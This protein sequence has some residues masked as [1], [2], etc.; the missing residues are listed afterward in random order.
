MAQTN[1]SRRTFLKQTA[2]PG[3]R[4]LPDVV[5]STV[6]GQGAPSNKIVMGAI[7]TG[8]MGMGDLNGFL[9]KDEVRVV[10]VCDVDK[11]HREN[12]KN[13][14][15]N[16][17]GNKDC[18]AYHDFRDLINRGDL[19]A[20]MTALPDHWHA[21]TSVMAAKAGLDIHG[22]K[23]LARSIREG[24]AICDAVHRYARVWQTGSWQRS[25]AHF[26]R[27]M[28]TR[29]QR[30]HRQVS[31][32][33]VGLPTGGTRPQPEIPSPTTS[34]GTSGSALPLAT[35][36]LRR[37]QPPLELA[38][39]HGL[40]RR[41]AHRLG[42]PQHRHRTLGLDLDHTG[43]VEIEGK[44]EFPPTDSTTCP[45]PTDSAASTPPAWRWSSPITSRWHRA[46]W[47]GEKAG[48]TSTAAASPPPTTR[49]QGSHRT[50]RNPA[51][52]QSR[53][54]AELPRLRESRKLTI[55]PVETAQ[56]PSASASSAKSQ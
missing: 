13:T 12:A 34:T 51:L 5:P 38:M 21:I 24:R 26:R 48:S 28:R 18:V 35:L 22:Q 36:R 46:K 32:V 41:P 6:F 40:L 49:S 56:G 55:T 11:R 52:Q 14:V 31:Y 17:Y 44:G 29:P 42:R 15:D 39:D 30:P 37:K 2:A 4:R 9:H 27:A 45:S 20:V 50:R 7:G 19:D 1:C 54:P 3:R 10:A 33:E 16:R 23:P 47:F 43:P 25:V 8:S 53:P